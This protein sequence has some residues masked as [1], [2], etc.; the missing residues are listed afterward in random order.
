MVVTLIK[1]NCSESPFVQPT[2]RRI[3]CQGITWIS[4]NLFVTLECLWFIGS[5][6]KHTS[7]CC[8]CTFHLH[9]TSCGVF[10]YVS[11]SHRENAETVE[12]S[13]LA[14]IFRPDSARTEHTEKVGSV[15]AVYVT[16]AFGGLEV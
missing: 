16:K 7:C 12:V 2:L 15:A 14:V 6:F 13:S 10:I 3:S 9:I 11:Q 1:D 4:E 5:H 8:V